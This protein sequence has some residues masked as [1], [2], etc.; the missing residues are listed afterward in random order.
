VYEKQIAPDDEEHFEHAES[1][2]SPK[3]REKINVQ[4]DDQN[5]RAAESSQSARKRKK[6]NE[7]D[8]Q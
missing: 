8:L 3:K 4:K 6:A 7:T 1:S 5:Y 2:H